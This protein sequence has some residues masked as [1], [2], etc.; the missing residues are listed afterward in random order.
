MLLNCFYNYNFKSIG[1]KNERSYCKQVLFEFF[2]FFFGKEKKEFCVQPF[3]KCTTLVVRI[4]E[5]KINPNIQPM[6][7]LQTLI[8][9]LY[10]KIEPGLKTRQGQRDYVVEKLASVKRRSS[11]GAEACSIDKERNQEDIIIWIF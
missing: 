5:I 2:S 6:V 7:Y 3:L 10:W 9:M 1:K 11:S 8:Q 4:F